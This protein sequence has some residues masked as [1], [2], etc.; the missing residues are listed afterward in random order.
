[1]ANNLF[2]RSV[3]SALALIF[4][5]TMIV[6]A[7]AGGRSNSLPRACA[8]RDLRLIA[9]IEEAGS[10]PHTSAEKLSQAGLG[11]PDA[12]AA[13]YEGRFEEASALY[14]ILIAGIASG[15]VPS[16]RLP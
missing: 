16:G 14:D 4:V 7:S 9:L 12:R 2:R 11:M 15:A 10:I 3:R 5:G 13:C 1:M 6:G 8:E